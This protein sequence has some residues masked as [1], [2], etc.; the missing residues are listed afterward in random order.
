MSDNRRKAADLLATAGT[1]ILKNRPGVHGSAELS[2]EM[3]GDFWTL[4]VRHIR[5]VRGSDRIR[6][7]DVA[8]MMAM[9]KKARKLYG[10]PSNED[11]DVDDI[12]YTAL[13]GMLRLPDPDKTDDEHMEST[14]ERG[15]QVDEEVEKPGIIT[16]VH[17][18]IN[19]GQKIDGQE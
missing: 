1:T 17:T 4:Y 8:E 16:H 9:L 13:A 6:P 10:D 2:F 15:L 19:T 7:E 14:L 12:G 3:I 18:G 11:N 5:R